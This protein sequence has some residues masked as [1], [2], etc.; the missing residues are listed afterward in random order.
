MHTL[1]L[2]VFSYDQIFPVFFFFFVEVNK[3]ST[4]LN[5]WR[6][7]SLWVREAALIVR[8]KKKNATEGLDPLRLERVVGFSGWKPRGLYSKTAEE[9]QSEESVKVQDRVGG[10]EEEEEVGKKGEAVS[11]LLFGVSGS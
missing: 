1:R 3:Y 9:S 6:A 4:F 8:S 11:V 2:F 5:S 7:L 10:A